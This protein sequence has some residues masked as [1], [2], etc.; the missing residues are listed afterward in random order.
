M[1]VIEA[2]VQRTGLQAS[3]RFRGQA[4]LSLIEVLIA[5][6]IVTVGL[7][8]MAGLQAMSLK[9]NSSAYHRTQANALAYDILDAMRSNRDTA[10]NGGYTLTFSGKDEQCD[11][12][13][14]DTLAKNDLTNWCSSLWQLLPSGVGAVN[15]ASEV[16]TATVRWNDLRDTGGDV[17]KYL[18]VQLSTRL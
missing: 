7:L 18:S 3:T 10:I 14:S 17:T 8:G 2:V 5:L 13:N 9:N 1:S 4:G 15:C 16:C 12:S 11:P 6:L